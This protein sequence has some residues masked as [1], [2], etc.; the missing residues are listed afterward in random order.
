MIFIL[1]LLL[2]GIVVLYVSIGTMLAK[3][4]PYGVA[5]ISAL[6][7]A[8]YTWILE[9]K[10]NFSQYI[11]EPALEVVYGTR[12]IDLY[13]IGAVVMVVGMFA[14]IIVAFFNAVTTWSRDA[15]FSLWR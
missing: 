1:T 6:G 8:V 10:A 4:K 14:V 7:G 11:L 12:A 5:S 2:I 15:P 3:N 13:G 9:T